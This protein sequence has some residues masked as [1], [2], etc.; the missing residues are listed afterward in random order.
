MTMD[1]EHLQ[2]HIDD[3]HLAPCAQII[4][5]SSSDNCF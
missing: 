4:L 2:H 3:S 5:S 1:D